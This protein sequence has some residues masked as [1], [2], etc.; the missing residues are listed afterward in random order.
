MNRSRS[1]EDFFEPA[2][3]DSGGTWLNPDD[4][5]QPEVGSCV[6]RGVPFQ[7]GPDTGDDTS[8]RFIDF[9]SSDHPVTI[10]IGRKAASVIFAHVVLRTRMWIDG[11]PPGDPVATYTFL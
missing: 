7:I 5:P 4:G 11:A 8:P 9:V 10:P 3:Y 6:F 1:T 2:R